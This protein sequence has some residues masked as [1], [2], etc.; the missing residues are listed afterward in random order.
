MHS[1]SSVLFA[2]TQ[3]TVWWR[4]L[5]G[6][7]LTHFFFKRTLKR[8]GIYKK[9]TQNP[10]L[11][12]RGSYKKYTLQTHLTPWVCRSV[13]LGN[14]EMQGRL[15]LLGERAKYFSSLYFLFYRAH[16][17]PERRRVEDRLQITVVCCWVTGQGGVYVV[18]K[19]G[20]GRERERAKER[21]RE[22]ERWIMGHLSVPNRKSHLSKILLSPYVPSL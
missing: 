10:L 19:G 18:L 3:C 15:T 1:N 14:V 22:T 11:L 5:Y 9:T 17:L 8:G 13:L 16:S 20:A 21:D 12:G 4:V 2:F 6:L 7:L